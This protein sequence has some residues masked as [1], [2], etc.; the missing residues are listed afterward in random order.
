MRDKP[1]FYDQREAKSFDIKLQREGKETK[2]ALTVANC[3]LAYFRHRPDMDY[4]AVNNNEEWTFIFDKHPLIY[5]MG[6]L[7]L[8]QEG[9][10]MLHLMEIN[11]GR[12]EERYGFNPDIVIEDY[13]SQNE[14][15][16]YIQYE[17]GDSFSN[18]HQDLNKSLKEDT[19]EN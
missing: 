9:Q 16:V 17:I 15:D 6:G 4:L 13:P 19:D 18:L 7:A 1:H 10:R 5:W 2:V 8:S 12:F 11:N 3:A 14:L